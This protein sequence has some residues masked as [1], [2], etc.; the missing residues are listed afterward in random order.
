MWVPGARNR[1]ERSLDRQSRQQELD[2]EWNGQPSGA[3]PIPSWADIS[4]AK[5]ER[6]ARFK[7]QTLKS[8]TVTFS[9]RLVLSIYFGIALLFIPI[10]AAI[11]A[12]SNDIRGSGDIIYSNK[13]L[14]VPDEEVCR[15]TFNLPRPVPKPSYLYYAVL[16]MHQN[17]LPYV[18]S[19][20]DKQLRGVTPKEIGEVENCFPKL[21]V[22][23]F[24]IRT[25]DN[26]REA[27]FNI[28]EIL[29]P[30]GL[31][32]LSFFNDSFTLCHDTPRNN[33]EPCKRVVKTSETGIAWDTD[34]K[35]VFNAGRAPHFT[36]ETNSLLDNEHFMVWMRLSGFSRVEKLYARIDESLPAGNLT[37]D[38]RSVYNV[39]GWDGEKLFYI[40]NTKWFG[41]KNTFLGVLYLTTGLTSLLIALLVL[42]WH[43]KYPRKPAQFAPDLLKRELAKL[44][45]QYSH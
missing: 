19:R 3:L 25:L 31:T 42:V 45:M 17:Y 43:I 4:E 15:F 24:A 22:D 27:D 44:S 20:S 7:Q 2:P 8:V 16:N 32:A 39:T 26:A 28:S 38:V 21:Y 18:T 29:N 36:N 10:G 40:S 11:L 37:M 5:A 13:T 41:G 35:Y 14:C 6:I 23:Q 9:P 30:C 34:K 12:G 1:R 33:R